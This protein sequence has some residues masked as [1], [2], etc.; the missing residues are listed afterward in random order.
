MKN[1]EVGA[2]YT[3][4]QLA[5]AFVTA[6]THEDAGT[7][8]RAE[9][10]VRRWSQ[11]LAG[12]ASGRVTVGSR[13]PVAGLPAWATPQVLRGGFATGTPAAGGSM[14]PHET[15]VGSERG[16]VFAHYLTDAGQAELCTLLDSG[17]YRL[18]F[19]EQAAL[20]A[21]AWLLRAGDR[22]RALGL[23]DEIGPFASRLCFT[24][25]P[26][27]V[28][29]QDPSV[30]WRAGAG[31]VG[32]ALAG[33][34][35]NAR[36]EAMREAVTVWNPFADQMLALWLETR[37]GHA[38][39]A[40]FP[41]GWEGRAGDLLDRYE[42]LAAAHTRCGKHRRP[43]ENLAIL[44]AATRDI[45][46]GGRLTDRRR[47]MLRHAV[48]STV[49]RRGR[50]GSPEH[51]A[52]RLV[53]VREAAIPAHHLLARV[54]VA[55]LSGLDPEAGIR[56]V[57]EVCGPVTEAEADTH[58]VPAGTPVPEPIRRVVRRAMAGRVDELL[59][60]GVLPSA[61]VLAELVPQLAAETS[62]AA[63]SDPA[64]RTLMAATY[65]AFRNRRS[66]LLVDLQHQV[67]LTELPWVRALR[68]HREAGDDT[69]REAHATLRRL[70]ELAL[71][72]FPAT[73][74]PNPLVREFA[75]LS[76]ESGADLPWV[77]ELAADIFM[78]RFSPKF[79]RAARLAGELLTDSVYARYYDIDYPA[80]PE[81][82]EP[83]ERGSSSA[84]FDAL[85]RG[86]AGAARGH[87][88]VAANGTVIEQ[89]QILTTHNLAT[90]AH[91]VGVTPA[92][93]W[94]GTAR[95]TFAMVLRITSRIDRNPRPLT[96]IKDVA[97]AWRH[98]VF[99]LSLPGA[100]DPRPLIE[101][102]HAD[103]ATAPEAVRTRL[104]PAV[105]GLGYVVAGGRFSAGGTPAGGRRLVGWTTGQHW[106]REPGS[107]DRGRLAVEY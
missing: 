31:E 100:G 53:Q 54:V 50:P 71:D 23:L 25:V 39:A 30:V 46:G 17:G 89:A 8:A 62:A 84:A 22:A 24:P 21:V 97:Y 64:L 90:L 99:C 88:G 72:G 32:A 86:R 36:V 18:E 78:G 55:R 57:H 85:C 1:D 4:G 98:L 66:L 103:L 70:G 96:T 34:R 12:M 6:L 11:V 92:D 101:G 59:D 93:G 37:A 27:P 58:P 45:T 63:Y 7:R 43:K 41:P 3:R 60:A 68:P 74:P 104:S 2:T 91:S 82:D 83:G 49:A 69:R 35:E 102:F 20:L 48:D 67:R 106:M 81:P 75:A 10:R 51:A 28:R 95:R 76:R 15:A 33:R 29:R 16:A 14:R 47:G 5:S 73:L 94:A 105:T 87:S 44:L 56:Q 80:L 107:G 77:E 65:R 61:E 52:L 26:D 38:V 13:T 19:P 42:A 79:V 40:V 9:E